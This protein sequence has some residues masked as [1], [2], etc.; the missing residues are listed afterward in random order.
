MFSCTVPWTYSDPKAAPGTVHKFV[1][2]KWKVK[3]F[4]TAM[5]HIG[6]DKKVKQ[7]FYATVH[8]PMVGQWGSK[9]NELTY[10]NIIV[11]I[12]NCVF[13]GLHWD[14]WIICT[15]GNM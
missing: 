5:L 13:V 10:Y 8:S 1:Y 3:A 15:E 2:C 14:N 7:L 4:M 6:D 9:F 11:I 12:T